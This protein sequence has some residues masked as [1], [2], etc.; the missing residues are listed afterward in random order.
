MN[1]INNNVLMTLKQNR[2]NSFM[3]SC[4]FLL[5]ILIVIESVQCQDYQRV[6]NTNYQRRK[7]LS[8]SIELPDNIPEAYKNVFR[9]AKNRITPRSTQTPN[10]EVRIYY[11]HVSYLHYTTHMSLCII[12]V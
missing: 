6:H 7:L 10:N 1:K 8:E 9:A 12:T 4:Y 2:N 3:C 5:A 11:N